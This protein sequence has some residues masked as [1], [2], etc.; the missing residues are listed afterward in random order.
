MFLEAAEF[1]TTIYAELIDAVSRE[2]DAILLASIDAAISE[3]KGY[4][5]DFDIEAIFAKTGSDRH[6]LLLTF[7]KDMAVWHFLALANPSADMELR[8]ARYERAIAWLKGVQK[9]D[10]IP[11]LP[12]HE[13]TGPL[14]GA[15]RWGS[16]PLRE[17]HY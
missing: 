2:D 14:I 8:K 15:I 16:Q 7:I 9:N 4:L 3:A 10:I 6:P 17:N 1:D 12:E 13:E 11:D 5:S